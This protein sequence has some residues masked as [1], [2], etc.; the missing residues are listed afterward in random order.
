APHPAH[1]R[2]LRG[3]TALARSGAPGHRRPGA[4]PHRD[5]TR[6]DHLG[7][8]PGGEDS[9]RLCREIDLFGA[10]RTALTDSP[11]GVPPR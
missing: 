4:A 2:T 11:P 10:V 5:P 1:R 8:A 3:A 6:A 9:L 7:P